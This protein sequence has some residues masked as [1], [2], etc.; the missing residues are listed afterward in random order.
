M[1]KRTLTKRKDDEWK[2]M[3]K[4]GRKREVQ[5]NEK[6]EGMKTPGRKREVC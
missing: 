2:G 5:Y 3:K 1:K 6:K 4:M